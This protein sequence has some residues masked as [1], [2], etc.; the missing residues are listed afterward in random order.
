MNLLK[1]KEDAAVFDAKFEQAYTDSGID[2]LFDSTL[3]SWFSHVSDYVSKESPA[4]PAEIALRKLFSQMYETALATP[5]ATT[6]EYVIN[7]P[8]DDP[9]LL[10]LKKQITKSDYGKKIAL[11]IS[12]KLTAKVSAVTATNDPLKTG[13]AKTAKTSIGTVI[14]QMRGETT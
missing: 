4:C 11:A 10:E 5:T 14:S 7:P 1:I 2:A 8:A 9:G 6:G 12:T 13:L 3:N